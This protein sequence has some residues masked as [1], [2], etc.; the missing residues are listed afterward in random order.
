[1]NYP[2]LQ[3]SPGLDSWIV[4]EPDGAVRV[5]SGKVDIGQRIAIDDQQIGVIAFS[6][7][8]TFFQPHQVDAVAG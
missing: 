4:L 5:K 3:N 2:S 7:G 1:M 8:A 6:D